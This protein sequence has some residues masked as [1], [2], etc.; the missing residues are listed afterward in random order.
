[1]ARRAAKCS[2]VCLRCALQY[3]PPVQRVAASPGTRTTGEAHTGHFSGIAKRSGGRRGPLLFTPTTSG[4]T[5]PARRTMTVSP[6]QTSLR[7]SS[8]SLCRVALVT[9]APPTNTG[10]R[11]ATGVRAPVRPT[12]TS[13]PRTSVV[14][15]SAGYLWASAKRGARATKPSRSCQSSRSTL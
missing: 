14:C 5:S 7:L 6:I 11:R 1:M 2:K 13:I 4:M 12:C 9:V 10:L 15:S 8:S 3:S